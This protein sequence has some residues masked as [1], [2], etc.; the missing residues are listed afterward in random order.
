MGLMLSGIP[1]PGVI[2]NDATSGIAASQERHA[3]F[4]VLK[5][6]ILPPAR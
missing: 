1:L 3:A 6:R 2:A 4:L 5:R